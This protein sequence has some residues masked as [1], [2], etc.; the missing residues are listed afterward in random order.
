MD[1]CIQYGHLSKIKCN[2][3]YNDALYFSMIFPINTILEKSCH[4]YKCMFY[5]NKFSIVSEFI[6][7]F[8]LLKLY[9]TVN[10]NI[11]IQSVHIRFSIKICIGD[12]KTLC[13]ALN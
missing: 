10:L 13:P 6:A 2:F 8:A 1:L 7:S 4:L 5:V 9:N 3:I 12:L 11:D